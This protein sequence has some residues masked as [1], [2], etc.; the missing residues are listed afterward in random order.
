MLN[1]F[2]T[3]DNNNPWHPLPYD[4]G[5][6]TSDGQ[7]QARIHTVSDQSTP[8]KLVDAWSL[9]RR[10]YLKPT[11]EGFFYDSFRD[12]PPFH[13]AL[14]HDCGLYS[15]N[16]FAAPRGFAKSTI[17]GLELPLL[18]LLTRPYFKI[19]MGLSTDKLVAGRFEKFMTLLSDNS[20]II[21]DFGIQKPSRGEG[22]WNHH[23][24]HM[25]NGSEIEG[26][27]VGGRKRGA[28][29]T[30]FILDDPEYDPESSSSSAALIQIDKFENVLFRQ[31]IPMLR[32][33]SSIVWIGT[34]LNSRCYLYYACYEN[35]TRFNSWNRKVYAS[36]LAEGVS[37]WPQ[38]WSLQ[39]LTARREEIGS[40]AFAAEYDNMPASAQDRLLVIDPDK[41]E[42]TVEQDEQDTK[43]VPLASKG[44]ITYYEKNPNTSE[45]QKQS[46]PAKDLYSKLFR[47]ITFDYGE[48]LSMHHDYSCALV[49]GFDNRNNLWIL[50]GWMGR[51]KRP[52]LLHTIYEL[53]AKWM[54][55]VIGLESVALQGD[56]PDAMAEYVNSCN[57]DPE[58]WNP[59]IM[60]IKY[61]SN[62][63][64]SD[65]ISSLEWRFLAGRIKYPSHLKNKWPFDRL[66]AQTQDF[67][68]DLALLRFDD[69]ID[70]VSMAQYVVHAK[71]SRSFAPALPATAAEMVNQGITT[72]GGVPLMSGLRVEDMPE[73]LMKA[74]IDKAAKTA[75][76]AQCERQRQIESMQS[77]GRPRRRGRPHPHTLTRRKGQFYGINTIFTSTN[78]PNGNHS[79]YSNR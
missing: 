66:Y 68:Y 10:L 26:F 56:L 41:N 78:N 28:R 51:A 11:P 7:R 31:I 13:Y 74:Y 75:Y 55:R 34:I 23:H 52:Q 15:R 64:K 50:D 4:Y 14:I 70:T 59:H 9:F 62:T 1:N 76:N 18:L 60:G 67:T 22:M 42:Y 63:S 44:L 61:P 69:A 48:G 24:I 39:D 46:M 16:A 6:L 25:N 37:L 21:D 40:A 77:T 79:G 20:L 71:G 57:P 45:F 38:E 49:M 29:P 27:S 33:G 12:S 73:D 72:L 30:L 54:V 58:R 32:K 3:S 65:R 35:D 47:I 19:A 36:G 2:I 43:A 53:G 17:L 8:M 5:E